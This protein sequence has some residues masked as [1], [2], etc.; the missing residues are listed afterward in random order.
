M[1]D[2]SEIKRLLL[3][4]AARDAQAFEQLYR[5]TAPLLLGIA[6]RVAG[7]RELA[8]EVLHDAFAKIWRAAP[9]S[10]LIRPGGH[11]GCRVV[12][13]PMRRRSALPRALS[14]A[15]SSEDYPADYPYDESL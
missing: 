4:T 12:A 6:L 14:R 10:L 1:L 8:E 9:A 13:R 5:R 2:D 7:R 3:Q 11:S 15:H